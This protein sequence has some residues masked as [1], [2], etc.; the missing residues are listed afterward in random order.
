MKFI[1]KLS[2]FFSVKGWRSQLP[3]AQIDLI[4]RTGIFDRMERT[5]FDEMLKSIQHIDYPA[6]KLI[7][8]EGDQGDALYIIS[9]GSVRVF[10]YDMNKIKVPIAR[11]NEGDYFGEQALLGQAYKTRNANIEA[12]T[13][14]SLLRIDAKFFTQ[15]IQKDIEL[16]NKLRKVGYSELLQ[17]LSLSTGFYSDLKTILSQIENPDIR[18][19]PEE[20]VIFNAGDQPDHVYI[21]LE[22]DVKLVFPNKKKQGAT[23]LLHRGQIFGELGVIRNKPRA[24]TAIAESNSRL[25]SITAED[26]KLYLEK[27]PQLQEILSKLEQIYR[28]PMQGSVE[29]YIGK[30]ENIG[31]T[32]TNIYKMEDDRL[33]ILSKFLNLDMFT[34]YLANVT[35]EESYLYTKGRNTTELDIANHRIIGIKVSG[36]REDLPKLCGLLLNNEVIDDAN[37]MRFKTTGEFDLIGPPQ[38]EAKADVICECM[39]VTRDKL[40]ALINQG[41]TD[42][43]TLAKK[44]GVGI[45][46]EGCKYKILEVLGESTWL[47]ALMKE[48]TTHNAYVKSFLLV[49]YRT[50]FKAPQAGQHV[51]IQ[52]RINDIW[53]ERPYTISDVQNGYFRITLKKE[54]KGLLG[55]W[56]FENTREEIYVNVTQPRGEFLI[57]LNEKKPAICFAGGIGIAP[58]IMYAKTL[59]NT[60]NTKRMHIVYSALTEQDFI[61]TDEFNEITEQMPSITIDYHATDTDGL[62]TPEQVIETVKNFHKPDIYI[63]GPEGFQ[64]MINQALKDIN[65][66]PQKIH[67]E[68]F[69][70]AGETPH[71]T[72]A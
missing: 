52:L 62:L 38:K 32:I 18:E 9:Q 28:I 3:A 4:K 47:S 51:I 65:Y 57:D 36:F 6:G 27:N 2:S 63:C 49:P 66:N 71:K 5:Q 42:V 72:A 10:T 70:H 59:L 33:I 60:N 44:S 37:L 30:V 1:K 14:T 67:V 69:V 41:I 50:A 25:L 23:L 56:L 20:E 29:Q 31:T 11:L 22:G 54:P 64:N 46:C 39:A 16:E 35:K 45:G 55:Q 15:L 7:F 40:E 26:F 12:I 17:I 68:K 48:I 58:F 13:D 21:I 19:F 24:A 34:M 43:E 61:L 53:I 8:H